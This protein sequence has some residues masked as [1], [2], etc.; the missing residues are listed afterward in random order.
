LGE[1]E[2]F[3]AAKIAIF[4]ESFVKNTINIGNNT[5]SPFANI[6]LAG[7]R[8]D[9][10]MAIGQN[11]TVGGN[12][13]Q[14]DPS[15]YPTII[16][17]DKI[18]IFAGMF[19][20]ASVY[21]PRFSLRGSGGN[22]LRW[23]GTSL[24][25]SGVLNAGGMKLGPDVNG[26]N[27]G[28]YINSNNYWY[29]TGTFKVGDGTNYVSFA[30]SSLSV[31]GSITVLGGDAATQTYAT[32]A[33]SASAAVVDTKVF[34]DSTGRIVKA[35]TNGTA[36]L[37][38]GS[39]NMGYHDGA[40]IWKTYMANNGNFYLTGTSGYLTWTAA[41]DTLQIKGEITAT[42]GTIGPWTI[43]ANSIYY[44]TEAASGTYASAGNITL[45]RSW[46][47]SANFRIDT[48]GSA[49]FTGTVTAS[50][51]T[52]GGWTI[53]TNKI[54]KSSGAGSIELQSNNRALV[55][56]GDGSIS[57][58]G[59]GSILMNYTG[60]GGGGGFY[61][62]RSN[63]GFYVSRW[64]ANA[65]TAGIGYSTSYAVFG[66]ANGSGA[67]SGAFTG[68][69]LTCSDNIIAYYSDERLKNIIGNIPN[70]LDKVNKLNGFYYTNNDLAK[71]VGY[72]DDKIQV[73]VSAQQIKD[74]LPEVIHLAP[75]DIEFDEITRTEKSKSGENYMTVQY[76]R[77]VP[78]L[79]EAIKELSNKVNELENKL[80]N[81]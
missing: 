62:F 15:T 2:F 19:N 55:F 81:K 39:T 54:Y 74:V 58:N 21:E 31:A 14:Y 45:G 57:F 17:Y 18:G 66:D 7:G 29:D 71:S 47:S 77:L 44:G 75:F 10:Y 34:T 80:K 73:G 67:R 4:D 5:G 69:N 23:A 43:G 65:H 46:L 76:D 56:T 20:N 37:F 38:L 27:D 13:V 70:A 60:T 28:L 12:N 63:N 3:V 42:S 48:D 41:T 35:P 26:A 50:S 51:G 61:M 25:M 16:G 64:E 11:G 68:G 53:D 6:V 36:G 24:D 79:I 52:I 1:Q 49:Y 32:T 8:D 30:G 78:I 33:A 9:P 40:G 59:N 22:Y 72:K